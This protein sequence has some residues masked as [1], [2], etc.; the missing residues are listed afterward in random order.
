MISGKSRGSNAN[1]QGG[2]YRSITDGKVLKYILIASE[3]VH[4]K[5]GESNKCLMRRGK[6]FKTTVSVPS[7]QWRTI[8]IP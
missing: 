3:S 7:K 5:V 1:W 2:N 4:L 8:T 6:E